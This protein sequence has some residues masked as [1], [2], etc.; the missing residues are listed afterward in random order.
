MKRMF[1]AY[2]DLTKEEF[3]DLW[4]NG[5]FIFDTNILYNF[6]RYSEEMRNKLFEIF[7]KNNDRIWLPYQVGYEYNKNRMSKIKDSEEVFDKAKDEIQ[8]SI[9]QI[10]ENIKKIK[11][12]SSEKEK[13]CEIIEKIETLHNEINKVVESDK[14]KAPSLKENDFIKDKLFMIFD[15]KVGNPYDKEELKTIYDDGKIR[16]E[17][18]IPPGY[19]DRGKNGNEQYGD[20]VIWKQ[21]IDKAKEIK[22][23]IIF[24]TDDNKEDWWWIVEGKKNSLRPELIK[25][26]KEAT[27]QSI[28]GY[29]AE[30]FMEYI[31]SSNLGIEITNE[32]IKEAKESGENIDII[33]KWQSIADFND[34]LYE[35]DLKKLK[36]KYN[37]TNLELDALNLI[38]HGRSNDNIAEIIGISRNKVD[39]LVFN[40]LCKLDVE[41]RV[42]AAVLALREGLV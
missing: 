16:Y 32:N 28:C 13:N 18:K 27:G 34:M 19:E 3:K 10:K 17:L 12:P 36:N 25:E 21:I 38:V 31:K 39:K 7:E 9:N 15:G 37:L 22:K 4:D 26:F 20:L 23:S 8:K 42:Q 24:I 29:T 40:I 1:S 2:C 30:R 33:H 5:I 11:Y 6:Y 35:K 41:D 14:K